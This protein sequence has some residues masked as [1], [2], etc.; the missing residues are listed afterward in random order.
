MEEAY[1]VAQNEINEKGNKTKLEPG[2]CVV[3]Q[4]N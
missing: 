1:L 4:V 3:A 2:D